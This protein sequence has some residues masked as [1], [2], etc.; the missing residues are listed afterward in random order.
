M[1]SYHKMLTVRSTDLDELNHVNNIRYLEWIQQISKEHW[2]Q[3]V[4]AQTLREM[5][6]VV[7][8]H[9]ITYYESALLNDQVSISTQVLTW[10]GPLSIREVK[11][12][13]NKSGKLL[14][15][16]KTEW[17]ALHSETLRPIRVP[18]AVQKLFME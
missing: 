18:E 17:C 7:R 16:A 5:V 14:V 13:N 1:L 11:M 6:W 3:R 10:R 12:V 4:D 8:N 9:N 2:E 15:M